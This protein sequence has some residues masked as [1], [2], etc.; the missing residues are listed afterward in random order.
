MNS[1]SDCGRIEASKASASRL[2]EEIRRSVMFCS[3]RYSPGPSSCTVQ[4]HAA[5][6]EH[7]TDGC[8]DGSCQCQTP[9]FERSVRLARNFIA[10]NNK[11]DRPTDRTR[12]E[13]AVPLKVGGEVGSGNS[14][15]CEQGGARSHEIR[16]SNADR[17]ETGKA[18]KKAF[19]LRK[20]F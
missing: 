9:I 3:W 5:R 6:R 7:G 1:S 20:P 18:P 12:D 4:E 2:T 19:R 8:C 13:W 10:K 17:Y 15:P 11:R 14:Q 16:E